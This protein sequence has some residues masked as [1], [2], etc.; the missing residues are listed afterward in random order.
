MTV[1]TAQQRN[2]LESAVKDA[3]RAVEKGAFNAL[4]SLGVDN[5]EP[6]QHLNAAERS[7]RNKLRAK[8]RLLGDEL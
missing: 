5:T 7:L 8:G 3:R 6:F 4:H 2:T 1:L